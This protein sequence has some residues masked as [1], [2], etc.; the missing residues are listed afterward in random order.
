MCSSEL[1]WNGDQGVTSATCS[2]FDE[3]T[4][5]V[6]CI[7]RLISAQE[8]MATLFEAYANLPLARALPECRAAHR[9]L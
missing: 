9:A 5:L 6:D 1:R 4:T 2:G 3:L 7:Q 8:L